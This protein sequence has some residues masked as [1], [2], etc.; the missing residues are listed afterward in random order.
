MRKAWIGNCVAIGEAAVAAEPLDAVQL[1]PIH[2]GISNLVALFPVAAET[3]PEARA[4]NAAT[5]SHAR[6]VRDFQIAHYR[7]NGRR[8]PFWD[9]ARS[10][11]GPASL[12]AKIGLFAA[13]GL[14]ALGD[15]EAF[16][17]QNWAASF[18]GQGLTPEGYHPVADA[19]AEEDLDTRMRQ[20]RAAVE[21]PVA[22]LPSHEAFLRHC[23][24]R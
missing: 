22:G 10:A 21:T 3:M 23:C 19:M 7:L 4:F 20:I 1:H 9:A 5:A 24:T 15:D 18:V 2:V 6:N 11:A 17:E 16:Q 13:R 8:E 12:N 14:V